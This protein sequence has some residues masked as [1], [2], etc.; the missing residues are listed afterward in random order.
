MN[1][2]FPTIIL[3]PITF[4]IFAAD[5]ASAQVKPGVYTLVVADYYGG[6]SFGEVEI[7]K[8][9]PVSVELNTG[10]TLKGRVFNNGVF[11]VTSIRGSGRIINASGSAAMRSK[12]YAVGTYRL[13][14]IPD[15]VF[16]L[17]RGKVSFPQP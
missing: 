11:R 10:Y 17:G 6:G 2:Q 12:T 16:I 5:S 7:E 1:C 4:L 13:D 14:G 3:V 8:P 9:G 15:G